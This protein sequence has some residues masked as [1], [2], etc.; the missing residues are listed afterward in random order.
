VVQVLARVE[1]RLYEGIT[2]RTLYEILSQE[3]AHRA[4]PE[5]ARFFRLRE[6]LGRMDPFVFEKFVENIL[7]RQE[8]TCEWNVVV[9]GFWVEHQID[10]LA[11]NK[12]NQYAMVE[13]KHHTNPHRLTGLGDVAELWARL[14]DLQHGYQESR[15]PYKF[16]HA[17]LVTNTKFSEHAKKYAT[18][19]GLWLSGWRYHLNG[20]GREDKNGLEKRIEDLGIT[21]IDK[22]MA[23]VKKETPGISN[24]FAKIV[25][26]RGGVYV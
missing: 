19:K 11:K 18:G 3:V 13:I 8:Y 9:P 21:E 25:K 17:W 16:E 5:S 4:P 26:K 23:Q 22:I 12:N 6:D 2:T 15:T 1:A 14:E 7:G 24:L 20:N 10:V